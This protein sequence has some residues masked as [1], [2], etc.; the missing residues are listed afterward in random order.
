MP[1]MEIIDEGNHIHVAHTSNR[2]L[3]RLFRQATHKFGGQVHEFFPT[4]R[5]TGGP[6]K[7]DCVHTECSKHYQVPKNPHGCL[8]CEEWYEK[9]KH[10][11][12][13]HNVAG[14]FQGTRAQ[15]LRYLAWVRKVA[16][17]AHRVRGVLSVLPGVSPPIAIRTERYAGEVGC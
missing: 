17:R 8:T 15:Q 7:L 16:A 3:Q 9:T 14:D 4:G 2:R 1:F 11:K 13:R 5:Y 12:R 10:D 6:D